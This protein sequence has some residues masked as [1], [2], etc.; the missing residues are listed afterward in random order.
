ML[1]GLGGLG[2]PG[3][4]ELVRQRI[5][6]GVDVRI[7]QQFL[8]GSVRLCD[9]ELGGGGL[10]FARSREAM[11]VTSE[12]WPSCM[13]GITFFTPIAAVLKTP[14]RTFFVMPTIISRA[15]RCIAVSLSHCFAV[16]TQNGRLLP[17]PAAC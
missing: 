10:R 8:I 9:A 13:P 12:Y 16:E 6:D 17:E 5:V 11:A 4:V 14:Q 2:G 3:H 7:G 1:A 15:P